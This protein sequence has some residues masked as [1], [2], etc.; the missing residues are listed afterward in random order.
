MRGASPSIG[1]AESHPK[2]PRMCILGR[3]AT[4]YSAGKG[5]RDPG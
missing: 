5:N 4:G 1:G 3:G 2:R